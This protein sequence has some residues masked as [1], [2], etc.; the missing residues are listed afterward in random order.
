MHR[1]YFLP[2][3]LLLIAI[4]SSTAHAQ[5][6]QV[7]N[8]DQIAGQTQPSTVPVAVMIAF[9]PATGCSQ[10]S[11]AIRITTV[12]AQTW[13]NGPC[14]QLMRAIVWTADLANPLCPVPDAPLC[15]GEFVP[16][17]APSAGTYWLA[18]PIDCVIPTDHLYFL[19]FEIV[20]ACDAG[21]GGFWTDA[22]SCVGYGTFL[23]G[24]NWFDSGADYQ[25]FA[26]ATCEPSTA[27][28]EPSGDAITVQNHLYAN[29][30]NPFNPTTTVTFAM[31]QAA[32]VK[33][34]IFDMRGRLVQVLV[35]EIRPA[36]NYEVQWSGTDGRGR[37]VTSGVYLCR[38][39]AGSFCET[40]RLTLVK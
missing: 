23:P 11:D 4:S 20:E 39:E 13:V 1:E 40:R 6:C 24:Y 3:L 36:G 32:H 16:V 17:S 33:L 18:L 29:Q 26:D 37:Q 21:G 10:C 9:D 14:E 28:E 5:D 2:L 35:D 12:R 8:L 31:A 22:T 27:I 15:A 34:S 19:G 38:M 30:P 25:F 7:G